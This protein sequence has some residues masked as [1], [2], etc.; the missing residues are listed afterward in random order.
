MKLN[1]F[2]SLLIS[3]VC[4]CLS[5]LSWGAAHPPIEMSLTNLVDCARYV[6]GY[7]NPHQ[8]DAQYLQDYFSYFGVW[9]EDSEKIIQAV[10]TS[11]K[12]LTTSGIGQF[13]QLLQLNR[14]FGVTWCAVQSQTQLTDLKTHLL[15]P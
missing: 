10:L 1:R 9:G 8:T 6:V 3:G 4:L 2:H 11:P 7:Q 5:P 12:M 13:V 15:I 14:D